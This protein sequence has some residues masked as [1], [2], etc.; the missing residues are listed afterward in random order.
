MKL[1]ACL[2]IYILPTVFVGTTSLGRQ[3]RLRSDATQSLSRE[4][5][6]TKLLP[7]EK[8]T[9]KEKSLLAFERSFFPFGV[10][11]FSEDRKRFV[12]K[13]EVSKVVILYKMADKLPGG[14]FTSSCPQFLVQILSVAEVP[15][16]DCVSPII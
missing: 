6:L 3:C 15:F 14:L 10:D 16:S 11:P 12:Y 1:L 2:F 13:T 5:T 4:A 9:S 7:F 8:C